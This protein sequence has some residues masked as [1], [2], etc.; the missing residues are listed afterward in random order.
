MVNVGSF[1]YTYRYNLGATR[2]KSFGV[3]RN[4]NGIRKKRSCIYP[5]QHEDIKAYVENHPDYDIENYP[6][7]D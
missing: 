3:P 1:F 2:D 4:F 6:D 7:Y 5:T